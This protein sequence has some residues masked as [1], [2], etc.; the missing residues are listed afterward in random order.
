[1]IVY[2]AT[3][4][5]FCAH[6]RANQ[7]DKILFEETLQKMGRKTGE[8]EVR[9]WRNSLQYMN[10]VLF[11][12]DIPEDSLVA[13]E[14]KIP[15]TSN[16]IDFIITGKN[17][18]N[19]DSAVIVE[20]KQWSS[21]EKTDKDAVVKVS[22]GNSQLEVVH[23]SYQAWSYAAHLED[24]NT[25]VQDNNIQLKPCAYLHNC[26]DNSILS[27]DF[28][29]THIDRAPIFFQDDVQKLAD[30]IKK[31][32]KHGDK[33]GILYK[34]DNGKVR[35]SKSLADQ[36]SSMIQG[37][38]EFILI[39]DQKLVFETAVNLSKAS[40]AKSKN[41]LIVEG[42]PGSGKSVVAINLLVKFTELG[43]TTQYV[44]KNSAPR[45]VFEQ[46]LSGHFRKSRISN[47]FKGSGSY[48]ESDRNDF[49]TLIIDEAHRMN[50]KS[51]MYGNL[52][53][54]QVLEV[55]RGST[56]SVFFI[57]ENQRV[58]FKD[59]GTKEEIRKW[60]SKEK[61]QVTELKLNSQFRCNGSDG[62]LAWLD[63]VL[64]IKE[65]ANESLSDINYE[66]RVFDDPS[67]L[68]DEI[69]A[70][71]NHNNKSRIV[72][73]YCWKW[74]S[75]KDP[76]PFDIEIGIFKMKWN[77]VSHGSAWIIH[78]ESVSEAG[79]IHTCQGLELDYVGVIIGDDFIVRD[80]IVIT[81]GTKRASSDQSIKGFKTMLRNNKDKALKDV[82]LIIK[83]TYRTLMTRGMK[84]CYIYCT[85]KETREYFKER[86]ALYET[87]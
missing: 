1:M 55:I 24:F 43:K 34:I 33:D 4:K 51:G 17:D 60:A 12:S 45:A 20:L 49:D 52:G 47:M 70:K 80:G 81:D 27:D 38:E 5:E 35:P 16:R 29:Q 62:Y 40:S 32:V 79:C 18:D 31:Y 23:P 82:D 68:R 74:P 13:L 67:E 57:D 71:N 41:V 7:I 66:F 9:S 2:S 75:K 15:G 28:Y 42:G 84:G 72:A 76:K 36:L 61:A 14:Y 73:G 83:N 6:V 59:I 77:L 22:Y 37:N 85:D 11:D 87:A 46:K 64:H 26:T 58:T 21:A 54:N 3:K 30:F 63:N 78:P 10:N 69:M 19:K 44:T 39:D 53:E 65:T 86:L 50:E 56:F 48:T 25:A 8:S